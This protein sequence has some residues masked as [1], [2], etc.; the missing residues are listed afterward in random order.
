MAY[1]CHI[2][3]DSLPGNEAGSA[4]V[5]TKCVLLVDDDP[6]LVRIYSDG[7]KRH[8]FTVESAADGILAFQAMR[9]S[10]PDVVILDLMMPRLPGQEVLKLMRSHPDLCSIPVIVLSNSYMQ[11]LSSIATAAGSVMSLLKVQCSPAIL[12]EAINYTLANAPTPPPAVQ[13][14]TSPA[15]ESSLQPSPESDASVESPSFEDSLGESDEDLMMASARAAA[16]AQSVSP[17]AEIV[18]DEE[19]RARAREEFLGAASVHCASIRTLFLGFANATEEVRMFRL[20][21]LYRKIH[22]LTANAGLSECHHIAQMAAV[23]EAM[24]YQVMDQPSRITPSVLRTSAM[25]IDFLQMLFSRASHSPGEAPLPKGRVLVVDDDPVCTRL[26]LWA[27]KQA[28]LEAR[29]A[30]DC[31]V[32]LKLL[33]KMTFDLIILD[34]GL[35]GMDGIQF[36]KL[37][38]TM[39]AHKDVPIIHCTVHTDFQTR[40]QSALS[41][42]DDFISK[43]VLPMELALKAV[44]HLIERQ[45]PAWGES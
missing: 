32:A 7:L 45:A 1:A 34:I 29:S 4:A 20:Q 14:E 33:E 6:T 23:F 22:F 10:K 17:F 27:L 3:P 40:T 19:V 44:M 42:G 31:Q 21:D 18:R 13:P 11:E 36:C 41:G 39:P 35:P 43:P 16:L 9:K 25:A 12:A 15:Q 26:V 5:T 37:L 8:G 38:R 30:G 24:L 28:H 2:K